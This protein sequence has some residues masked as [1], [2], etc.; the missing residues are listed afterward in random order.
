MVIF[1]LAARVAV[2]VVG[3]RGAG[4]ERLADA[5]RAG[6][7]HIHRQLADTQLRLL[8]VLATML[9]P[10]SPAP[11]SAHLALVAPR[12]SPSS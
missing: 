7:P 11:K 2:E 1:S 6:A 10:Y 9:K 5:D 4:G 12:P 3:K 8:R